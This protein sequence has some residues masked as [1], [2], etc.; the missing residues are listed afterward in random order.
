MNEE[1][2]KK[3]HE[4]AEQYAR[5]G[6]GRHG[7]TEKIRRYNAYTTGFTACSE[8]YE[9]KLQELVEQQKVTI[10]ILTGIEKK[11][12]DSSQDKV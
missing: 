7:E 4:M 10:N 9:A 5:M 12:A 1:L 2:L 3:M 11:L 8:I 6:V